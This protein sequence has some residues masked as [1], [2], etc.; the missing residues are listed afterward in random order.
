[1]KEKQDGAVGLQANSERPTNN[2]NDI[3]EGIIRRMNI[4]EEQKEN[5]RK[6]KKERRRG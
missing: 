3:R 2:E 5:R 6:T 4:E 1:M